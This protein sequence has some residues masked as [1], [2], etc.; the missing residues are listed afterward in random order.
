MERE[1]LWCGISFLD[2]EN[3]LELVNCILLNGEF[4]GV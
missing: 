1:N 4:C 3:V 2:N